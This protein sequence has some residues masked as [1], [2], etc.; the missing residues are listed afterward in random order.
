VARIWG[1]DGLAAKIDA[2][3][4]QEKAAPIPYASL[5]EIREK[6]RTSGINL[7]YQLAAQIKFDQ[8]VGL[9]EKNAETLTAADLLSKDGGDTVLFKI[10]QQGQLPLLLK[11]ELWIRNPDD[12]SSIWEKAPK[13][14]QKDLDGAGVLSRARQA[15][16]QS[17]PV[18]RPKWK[19]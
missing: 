9:A 12:F 18:S 11:P 1:H 7:F 4:R 10:C 19:K 3:M 15:G 2:Q 17:R 6:S 5:K 8:V 14:C 13:V 16:L